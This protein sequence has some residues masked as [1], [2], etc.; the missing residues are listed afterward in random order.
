MSQLLPLPPWPSPESPCPA[1]NKQWF[2]LIKRSLCCH[3]W[4]SNY[5]ASSLGAF[6]V[7][8]LHLYFR[9]CLGWFTFTSRLSAPKFL[10]IQ[11]LGSSEQLYQ[12]PWDSWILE[13]SLSSDGG[14]KS[15]LKGV[16][17]IGWEPCPFTSSMKTDCLLLDLP[18]TSPAWWQVG[19][20]G[21]PAL[22]AEKVT[23][24]HW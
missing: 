17:P 12:I 19:L 21:T 2:F 14:C 11:E 16:V 4:G 3:C 10:H 22:L 5:N 8:Q 13:R 9:V 15:F 7:M 20:A 23:A 24:L 18:K 6:M 1:H